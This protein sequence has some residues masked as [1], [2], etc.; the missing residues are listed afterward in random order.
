MSL[1]GLTGFAGRGTGGG[2]PVWPVPLLSGAHLCGPETLGFFFFFFIPLWKNANML[3]MTYF[4]Q[5]LLPACLFVS[6]HWSAT[7]SLEFPVVKCLN[8]C[9]RQ[10]VVA[11]W[12]YK[13]SSLRNTSSP[14]W[15]NNCRDHINPPVGSSPLAGWM[16]EH[17]D[18]S[19]IYCSGQSDPILSI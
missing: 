5:C 4:S 8:W 13:L 15:K 2:L 10:L 17:G 18:K 14:D 19:K 11:A 9:N 12:S 1:T 3:L 16:V 6:L 7:A